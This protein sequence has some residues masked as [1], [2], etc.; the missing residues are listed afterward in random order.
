MRAAFGHYSSPLTDM[1]M[2]M[3]S[4]VMGIIFMFILFEA[5]SVAM[6]GELP[7]KTDGQSY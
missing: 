6:L 5:S 2:R 4:S 3:F 7:L 1:A